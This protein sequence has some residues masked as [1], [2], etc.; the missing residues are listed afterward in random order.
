M[1][2]LEEIECKMTDID[3]RDSDKGGDHSSS[4]QGG[5]GSNHGSANQTGRNVRQSI[6]HSPKNYQFNRGARMSEVS[7]LSSVNL[8]HHLQLNTQSNHHYYS[9][10]PLNSGRLFQINELLRQEE[11]ARLD[12]SMTSVFSTPRQPGGVMMGGELNDSQM[13]LFSNSNYQNHNS[14]IFSPHMPATGAAGQRRVHM[15]GRVN[16]Q[17]DPLSMTP[18]LH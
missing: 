17:A 12:M 16:S 10:A 13:E 9:G 14:G 3:E 7:M 2:Q 8:G 5:H 18:R 4:G 6:L 11:G 15:E 1:F